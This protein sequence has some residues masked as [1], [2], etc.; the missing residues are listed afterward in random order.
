[1]AKLAGLLV[2]AACGT[3]Q[4]H[5][6]AMLDVQPAAGPA[7]A[8]QYDFDLLEPVRGTACVSRTQQRERHVEVWL[9]RFALAP[10]PADR[11]A[12]RAIAAASFDAIDRVEGA[13]TLLVT[14]VLTD[15]GL[16]GETCAWVYGRA[17]RLKKAGAPAPIPPV[18]DGGAEGDAGDEATGGEPATAEPRP[19]D[20]FD[21]PR[22]PRRDVDR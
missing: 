17:V 3:T 14:R 18:D 22:P 9:G 21:H 1:M 12:R 8:G 13:D 19:Y 10:S 2:L 11:F 5:G 4:V 7:F 16:H 20:V 15:A 6:G